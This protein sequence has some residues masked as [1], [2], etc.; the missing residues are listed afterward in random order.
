MAIVSLCN[1]FA[2]RSGDPSAGDKQLERR[3]QSQ[4]EQT[5]GQCESSGSWRALATK[6]DASHQGETHFL[7]PIGHVHV[8][9]DDDDDDDGVLGATAAV[10]PPPPTTTT[11][12]T[13]EHS[14]LTLLHTNVQYNTIR[15]I[16]VRYMF[17][18]CVL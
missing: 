8:I 14:L 7:F 11:T 1:I 9:D 12:T 17:L 13:V 6:S 15:T 2:G 16:I 5:V 3:G 18:S 4:T 10:P